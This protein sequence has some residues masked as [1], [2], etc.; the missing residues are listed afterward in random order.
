M[1]LLSRPQDHTLANTP[2]IT[3]SPAALHP[4]RP[5]SRRRLYTK[6]PHEAPETSQ[7]HL[8]TICIF[9]RQ[10]VSSPTT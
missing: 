5:Q 1:T 8:R 6:D 2:S 10:P 7:Y 9:Q 4:T 3:E